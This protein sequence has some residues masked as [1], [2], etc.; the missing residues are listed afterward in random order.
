MALSRLKI[1]FKTQFN[2]DFIKSCN[3]DSYEGYFLEADVQYPEELNELHNNLTF[4]S[5]KL[6]FR[7]L[8]NL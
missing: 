3:E 2:E 5:K 7:K 1:Q 6:K 8:K 4:L